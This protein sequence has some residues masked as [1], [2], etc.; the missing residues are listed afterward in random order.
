M[1]VHQIN[2]GIVGHVEQVVSWF[3]RKYH[4]ASETKSSGRSSRSKLKRS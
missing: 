1:P 2:K 3:D 4:G